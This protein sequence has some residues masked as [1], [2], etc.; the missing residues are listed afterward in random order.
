MQPDDKYLYA[1][2]F[3][4]HVGVDTAKKFHMMVARGPDGRRTKPHKVIVSRE[5]FD[6]ADAHLLALFPDVPRERM[7]VGLE[8][9]GHHGF[10]FAHH[11]AR[12]GY[13]IVNVLPSVTKRSKEI[14]DNSPLKTD[15]KDAALI[16]K[17]VGDGSFVRFPFLDE[18]YL[19]LRLLTTERHRLSCE[20]VRFKNRLQAILDLAWPEFSEF[21]SNLTDA[22]PVALLERWPLPADL[23]EAF[24]PLVRNVTKV[25]SRNHFPQEKCDRL[26]ATAAISVG[27]AQGSEVR[28]REILRLLKRWTVTRQQIEEV[29]VALTARVE[30]SPAAKALTSIPEVGAVCAATIVA[31]L[32]TPD[33]YESPRQVLKLAGMNLVERSSGLFRGRAK[34]SKRGR[35]ELRR[36]LFLLAC[37][38]VVKRQQ[39]QGLYRPYYDALLARNGGMKS[40]ALCAVARKLVPLL[41]Q[42]AKS[43]VAFDR[44]RWLGS[45]HALEQHPQLVG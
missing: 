39:S 36:Q 6:G 45:R 23:R 1:H 25:M 17:L 34:Q 3:P 20:E 4:V 11:L 43:R 9:A 7:L 28:R 22:T 12:L 10:T 5:G 29:E 15:A 37:R 33:D 44:E 21:F 27:L 8:F 30:R 14:E 31:E 32:G 26:L 38:W 40:K 16:A 24:P 13:P 2:S 18:L 42:V 35:P 41:L 19:E